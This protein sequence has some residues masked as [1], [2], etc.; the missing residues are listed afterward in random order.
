MQRSCTTS[1]RKILEDSE[2]DS[3][4]GAVKLVTCS[5][6]GTYL[7]MAPSPVWDP[8]SYLGIYKFV[9][10]FNISIFARVFRESILSAM[11]LIIMVLRMV[12]NSE[13]ATRC[14]A[15]C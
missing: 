15:P 12:V 1:M 5:V 10:P 8:H 2:T 13:G 4:G 11:C 3:G 9:G 6:P 7:F 14:Q